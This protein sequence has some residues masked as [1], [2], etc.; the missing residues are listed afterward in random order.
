MVPKYAQISFKS[1]R[2]LAEMHS[3]EANTKKQRIYCH[4]AAAHDSYGAD[5]LTEALSAALK[6]IHLAATVLWDLL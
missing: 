2:S 3:L 6:V 5:R 4:G 1:Q